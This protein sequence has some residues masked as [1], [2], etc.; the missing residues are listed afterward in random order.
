[1]RSLARLQRTGQRIEGSATQ[2]VQLGTVGRVAQRMGGFIDD[3]GVVTDGGQGADQITAGAG[4]RGVEGQNMPEGVDRCLGLAG[5][6]LREP[7][8]VTGAG[9]AWRGGGRDHPAVMTEKD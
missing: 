5:A 9:V 6:E 4:V 2:E 7:G 1:M 3:R 8:D